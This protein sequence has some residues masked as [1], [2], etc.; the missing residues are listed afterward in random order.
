MD[1]PCAHVALVLGCFLCAYAWDDLMPVAPAFFI[2][3]L[4]RVH[5][6]LASRLQARFPRAQFFPGD[7][8]T[9]PTRRPTAHD[10]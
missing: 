1:Q 6:R 3:N 9:H 5:G 7:H 4:A 2:R 8:S 10:W